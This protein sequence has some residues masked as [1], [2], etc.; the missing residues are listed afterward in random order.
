MN[1]CEICGK[2]FSS[3]T[4]LY[5]H[6][7]IHKK[8]NNSLLLHSHKVDKMDDELEDSYDRS[9]KKVVKRKRVDSDLEDHGVKRYRGESDSGLEEIDSYVRPRRRKKKPK[10]KFI[11]P[12]SD[13]ELD[14]TLEV[15]DSYD[16]KL[17]D[18]EKYCRDKL[19]NQRRK[20]KKDL[21]SKDSEISE[22]KRECGEDI[23][24]LKKQF[25]ETEK[26]LTTEAASQKKHY[27]ESI[28]ELEDNYENKIQILKEK[29]KS[30]EEG[31]DFKPLSDAIFNCTTIEE[32]FEI[33]KL[34]RNREFEQLIEKHLDT[35]QKLFLSLSYGV[36]P[37]CQPQRDVLSDSQKKL[38]Q[39]IE[40]SSP[41]KAKTLIIQNRSEII[42]IF[43]II[44]QSLE[45]AIVS[46]DK[47]RRL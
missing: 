11:K 40:T 3:L 43:H 22:I 20:Y 14:S 15:V 13:S 17:E 12:K 23:I 26:D 38:I 8:Q 4:D 32:I 36:I 28:R 31:A 18:Y 16:S 7:L 39:K 27:D 42:N 29:I 35:L 19:E 45:L 46:Y 34:V 44:E 33:K 47:F 41:S 10:R 5:T 30:M 2:S 25:K 6:K 24:N 37:I 9:H 1:S 21:E